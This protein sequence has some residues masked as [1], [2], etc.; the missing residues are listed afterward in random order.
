M[1]RIAVIE[2]PNPSLLRSALRCAI[3]AC[4]GALSALTKASQGEYHRQA[5]H[6]EHERTLRGDRHI[7]NLTEGYGPT[8]LLPL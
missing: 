6:E 7:E 3:G 2:Q 5:A 4:A 1:P 8:T